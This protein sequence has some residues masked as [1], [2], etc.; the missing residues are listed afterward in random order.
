ML[1]SGDH[2]PEPI[3][4]TLRCERS[5]PRRVT[6]LSSFEVASRP[7]QDDVFDVVH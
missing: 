7:P 6:A 5:E 3:S 2:M 4:V 1:L